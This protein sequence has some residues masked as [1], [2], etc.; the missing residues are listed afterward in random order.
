MTF[1]PFG[2]SEVETA[3]RLRLLHSNY[4]FNAKNWSEHFDRIGDT[5][6]Q[7]EKTESVC[8]PASCQID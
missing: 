7:V 8:L 5:F 6:G 2:R 1:G 3:S 4:K